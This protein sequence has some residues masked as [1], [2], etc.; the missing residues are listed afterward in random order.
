VL[1]IAWHLAALEGAPCANSESA[2]GIARLGRRF[3]LVPGLTS[4]L[5]YRKGQR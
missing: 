2:S 1:A 5:A 4:H 3:G